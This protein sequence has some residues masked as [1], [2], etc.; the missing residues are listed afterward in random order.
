MITNSQNTVHSM[1][2]CETSHINK[3]L[4][5]SLSVLDKMPCWLR[6]Y[7]SDFKLNRICKLYIILVCTKRLLF[8]I[9]FIVYCV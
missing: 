8:E 5:E 1:K 2:F 4:D 6:K 9:T 3:E 7:L